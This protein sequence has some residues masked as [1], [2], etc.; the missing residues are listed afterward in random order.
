V[1][2]KRGQGLSSGSRR[3]GPPSGKGVQIQHG[4]ALERIPTAG[5][6]SSKTKIAGRPA[7]CFSVEEVC[8]VAGLLLEDDAAVVAKDA[9][10]A[11]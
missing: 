2:Q 5:P 1:G 11:S 4:V 7:S 6:L 9:A 10:A 3:E 8:A